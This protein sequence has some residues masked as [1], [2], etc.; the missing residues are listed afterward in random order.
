MNLLLAR[1]REFAKAMR[2]IMALA[3]IVNS[4][5]NEVEPWSLAKNEKTLGRVQAICTTALNAF[6]LL[7][8]YL[9]PVLPSLSLRVA[10]FLNVDDLSYETFSDTLFN[11]PIQPF[12]TLLD[13]VDDKDVEKMMATAQIEIRSKDLGQTASEIE[14]IPPQCSFNDFI[15]IDLRVAKIISAESVEGADKLLKLTLDLGNETR[16]VF[17]GIKHVYNESDLLGRLTVMVA[18]LPP[19]KMKFGISEGMILT[20]GSASEDI[21]LLQ[22]DSGAQPGQR[23][24]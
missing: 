2:E 12:K 6:R 20:A 19:R 17:S 4:W 1:N 3:D 14:S 15:K 10:E 9:T 24:L 16:Q 22:V 23:I 21:F 5:I 13:R 11:H 8:I 7:M 18:N